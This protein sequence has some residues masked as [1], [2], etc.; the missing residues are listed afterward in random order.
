MNCDLKLSEL[1]NSRYCHDLAGPIGAINNGVEFL[2]E[3]DDV[4]Q[5]KARALIEESSLQ[6]IVRL[7]FFRQVYGSTPEIGE[8]NLDSLKQFAENYF[9]HTKIKL[10]WD[11]KELLDKNIILSHREG[12]VILNMIV[13]AASTLIKGGTI[14]VNISKNADV[15]LIVVATG[16]DIKFDKEQESILM[17][18][19]LVEELTSKNIQLYYTK[20]LVKDINYKIILKKDNSNFCMT[21]KK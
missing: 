15:N 16:D 3:S 10:L 17:Q 8:A 7:Q 11:V 20:L 18:E 4:M 2:N 21:V 13:I 1:L 12:K 6:A 19:P 5:H 9:N 14:S